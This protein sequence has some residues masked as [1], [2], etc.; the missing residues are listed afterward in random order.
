[1]LN[2]DLLAELFNSDNDYICIFCIFF[3]KVLIFLEI[4]ILFEPSFF[5][6]HAILFLCPALN[7]SKFHINLSVKEVVMW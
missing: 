4:V 5:H 7:I 6:W 3:F 1:M 2:E